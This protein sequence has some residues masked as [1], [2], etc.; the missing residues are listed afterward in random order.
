ML[1]EN[2]LPMW[3]TNSP[4]ILFSSWQCDTAVTGVYH[5]SSSVGMQC[6]AGWGVPWCPG[7]TI[8]YA[9]LLTAPGSED[10][11]WLEAE[12]R[13]CAATGLREAPPSPA[14]P[15]PQQP[16]ISS[17]SA[18]PA[19]SPTWTRQLPHCNT[20]GCQVKHIRKPF[21]HNTTAM[22]RRISS[23]SVSTS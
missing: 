2:C 6:G 3:C 14:Q 19:H 11:G 4:L 12:A 22:L 8:L 17:R 15:R 21:H 23:H 10:R 5:S 16:N 13:Q 20:G 1:K 9:R 7:V 18:A